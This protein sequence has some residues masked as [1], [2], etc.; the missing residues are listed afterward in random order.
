ML[1]KIREGLE[2]I[3]KLI[4]QTNGVYNSAVPAD[5]TC[6]QSMQFCRS[7]D[8]RFYFHVWNLGAVL[9]HSEWGICMAHHSQGKTSLKEGAKEKNWLGKPH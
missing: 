5:P 9:L 4:Q 1:M 2:L 7:R 3:F 8:F 6:F